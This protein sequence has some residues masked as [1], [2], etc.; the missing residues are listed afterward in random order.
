MNGLRIIVDACCIF[1]KDYFKFYNREW[2]SNSETNFG[3]TC[4]KFSMK[5]L[6]DIA[7]QI[8][9]PECYIKHDFLSNFNL[10]VDLT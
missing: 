8:G 3:I 10:G 4:G 7:G 2:N 9:I 1:H 6:P 5:L